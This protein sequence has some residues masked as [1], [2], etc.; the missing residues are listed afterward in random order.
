MGSTVNDSRALGDMIRFHRKKSGLTQPGL[1]RLA[2]VG[3][4]AVFDVEHGKPSVQLDTLLKIFSVLN[5]T[6]TFQ[7]PLM[8]QHESERR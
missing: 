6:L 5:I 4:T 8:A 7:S 1:A 3:K 2:Q